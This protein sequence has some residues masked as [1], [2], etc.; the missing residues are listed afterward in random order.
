MKKFLRFAVKILSAGLFVYQD[1]II[2]LV[3]EQLK[4]IKSELSEKEIVREIKKILKKVDSVK[5][6]KI[7]AKIANIIS[8]RKDFNV[9][10]LYDDTKNKFSVKLGN[11]IY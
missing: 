4:N 8:N 11:A 5:S 1:E 7:K 9:N 6:K 10:V 2:E 3:E